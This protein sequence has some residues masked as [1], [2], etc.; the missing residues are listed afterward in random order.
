MWDLDESEKCVNLTKRFEKEW[1]KI[2]DKYEINHK[3][4][5]VNKSVYLFLMNRFWRYIKDLEQE[6]EAYEKSGGSEEEFKSKLKEPSLAFCLT[7][8]FY[9]KFAA[10]AFMKL[11]QDRKCCFYVS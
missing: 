8:I 6:E 2:A 3:T 5:L 10:G 4:L 1:S 9:G 7:K 11:I